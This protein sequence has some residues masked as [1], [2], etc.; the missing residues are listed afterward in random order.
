VAGPHLV[1]VRWGSN[2]N[3]SYFILDE[4]ITVDLESGPTPREITRGQTSFN[5]HGYVNDSLNGL[6][7]KFVRISVYMVDGATDYSSYLR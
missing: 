6:S 2:Y 5:L 3:Y 4:P 1:R 7:I